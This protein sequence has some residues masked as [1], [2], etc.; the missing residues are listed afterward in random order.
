M[1]SFHDLGLSSYEQKVYVA[2]LELHAGDAEA[3]SG[4]SDV[5]MGRIYDVLGTLESRGLIERKP[6][7]RPRIYSPV[8]PET[9]IERLLAERT[10][11]LEVEQT[12]YENVAAELRAEYGGRPAMEGRFWAAANTEETARLLADRMETAER[13]VAITA[14]TAAGGL[15]GFEAVYGE[16]IERFTTLLDRDVSIRLLVTETLV[17]ELPERLVTDLDR[18]LS[19]FDRFELRTTPALHNTYDMI[20]RRDVCVYVADP[21]ERDSILGTVRIADPEF[22]RTV[23]TQQRAIWNAATGV[24]RVD[25]Q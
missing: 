22:V 8:D 5:P 15:F 2:L 19:G 7:S 21:F 4:A 16:T 24:E 20:D 23:D 13:D 10:R 3:I 11:E 17:A 14:T 12:R 9:V 1:P 25:S 6:E 18:L